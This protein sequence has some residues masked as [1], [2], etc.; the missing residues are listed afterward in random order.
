MKLRITSGGQQIGKTF[1]NECELVA[2]EMM[3]SAAFN[4]LRGASHPVKVLYE[5]WNY[6]IKGWVEIGS[7]EGML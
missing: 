4:V 6:L 2:K 3:R 5:K 1:E 7:M